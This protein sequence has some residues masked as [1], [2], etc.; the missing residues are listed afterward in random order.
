[1]EQGS[2]AAVGGP[3]ES[4]IP[5]ITSALLESLPRRVSDQNHD[6][7]DMVNILLV[8]TEDDVVKVFTTAGWVQVDKSVGSTLK[9]GLEDTFHKKDYLTMPMSTLYLF[10]R[11]QDYGF[12][13]AEPV[14]VVMSRNHLRVWKSPH[15]VKGRRLWSVGE[16]QDIGFASATRNNG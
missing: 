3:V 2:D 8:G 1:L 7:G 16:T 9:E 14:R 4:S 11:P 10:G 5:E 12:A 15:E 6:P 13:H